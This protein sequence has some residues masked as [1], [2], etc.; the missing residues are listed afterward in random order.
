MLSG[1]YNS[2]FASS[3]SNPLTGS[4]AYSGNSGAFVTTK[5]NLAS[6]AGQNLKFR[7]RFVS[8]NNTDVGSTGGWYIDDINFINQPLVIMRSNLFN[9][10]GVRVNTID[11]ILPIVE[12]TVCNPVEITTQPSA[13]TACAGSSAT[14]T[15]T[16]GG[17]APNYQWQVSTNGG[18]TWTDISGATSSVLTV[19]STTTGQNGNLYRVVISNSCPSSITSNAVA[20]QVQNPAT[21]SQQPSNANVCSGSNATF[22][23]TAAGTGITYQW[24]LSNDG[25]ANWTNITGATTA[26]YTVTGVTAAMNGNLYRVVITGCSAPINSN[27]ATLNVEESASITSHPAHANVCSGSDA[28]FSVTTAGNGVTYQWQVSTNGGTTWT[29]ITGATSATYTVS[30]VDAS[31]H[32]NQYRVVINNTC[33]TNVASSAATLTVNIA[34]S[35]NSQPTSVTVCAGAPATFQITADGSANTYQWQVSTDGGN[36]WTNISGATATTYTIASTDAS[37]HNNRYRVIVTSC[38]GDLPSNAATLNVNAPAVMDGQVADVTA[39]VGNDATFTVSVSGTNPQYQW[40]VSTDGGNTWTNISG[41]T[42]ATLSVANVTAAH[43]GYQYRVQ[44]S[45]ICTSTFNSNAA[46]LTI[47]ATATITSHPQDVSTC[48]G[49]N[50]TFSVTAS[51]SNLGYQWQSS[52]DGGATWQDIASATSNSIVINN[53][54]PAYSGTMVRVLVSSCSPGVITSNTATLTVNSPALITTQPTSVSVCPGN[55]ATFTVAATGINVTYQW[56]V[57]TNGGTSWTNIAGATNNTYTV[58]NTTAAQNGNMYMVVINGVCTVDATSFVA[59]LNVTGNV[60]INSHPQNTSACVNGNANFQ[61]TATNA[62]SYQWQVSTDGGNTWSNIAGATSATLSVSNITL[63]DDQ[64]QYRVVVTGSCDDATSNAGVLT[65]NSLPTVSATGPSQAV[66]SGTSI[67]LSGTGANTYTWDNN[68][69]NGTPFTVTSTTTYTVTGTDANGCSASSTITVA[70]N[71]I[72]VVT[73]TTTTT[74]LEEGGSTVITATSNPAATSYTWYYNGEEIAGE[75]GNTITVTSDEAGVYTATVN[76]NDCS[77]SSNELTITVRAPNFAFISPNPNNGTFY[78]RMSNS[79][80]STNAK[81]MVMVYDAKGARVFA[82]PFNATV[83][84]SFD[85][86]EI[87]LGNVAAGVYSLVV[88]EN[89]VFK[90]SAQVYINR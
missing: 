58:T 73:I 55:D 39:C 3:F 4:P 50:A 36:T 81:R 45:N 59:T 42:G 34:A 86:Y 67:T 70:V 90:K 56:Q 88:Y 62:N 8:D 21:I 82:K 41:A 66:C 17:T 35:L 54:T 2:V 24:Q 69:T 63:A 57:S 71:P 83:A 38:A 40:Q 84:N 75:T 53:V 7:F 80:L 26:S 12:T 14:F 6:F 74:E 61:A 77:G 29:N 1:F 85:T 37:M 27:N 65:V 89:G 72:P 13:V 23:V 28:T 31:H 25:G 64:N 33:A 46:T 9:A 15:V 60:A 47:S 68:V 52:T 51:G 19:N 10:S 30:N 49:T 43:D 20:L 22:S 87:E 76:V 79:G 5:L 78:V 18:T 16:A 11:S 44:I 32:N 48:D